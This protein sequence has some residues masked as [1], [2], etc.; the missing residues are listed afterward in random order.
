MS[1]VTLEEAKF[2]L[3]VDGTEEDTL[4][5]SKIAAA[6]IDAQRHMNRNVYA[7]AVALAAA[8]AAVPAQM[9]DA[10]V[11]YDAATD[12]ACTLEGDQRAIAMIGANE[13]YSNA[14]IESIRTYRGIVINEAIKSAILLIIGDLYADRENSKAGSTSKVSTASVDLL[15]KFRVSPGV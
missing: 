11:T 8:I 15:N 13:A 12:T 14:K 2:Q 4:I 3:R 6:E 10:V 7:D 5:A 9:A 1:F